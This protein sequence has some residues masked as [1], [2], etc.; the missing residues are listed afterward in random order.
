MF[1]L[2][3]TIENANNDAGI[4]NFEIIKSYKKLDIQWNLNHVI[5][6]LNYAHRHSL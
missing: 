6:K 1:N 3:K 5:E 4:G 2:Y